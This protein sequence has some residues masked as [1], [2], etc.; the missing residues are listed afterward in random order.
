MVM[1]EMQRQGHKQRRL[2]C[3]YDSQH[4]SAKTTPEHTAASDRHPK[5]SFDGKTM[6]IPLIQAGEHGDV[7]CQYISVASGLQPLA[8]SKEAHDSDEVPSTMYIDGYAY[9]GE[10]A[11]NQAESCEYLITDKLR[12]SYITTAALRRSGCHDKDDGRKIG[13]AHV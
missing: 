9:V 7:P 2:A 1:Q 8:D 11:M 10:E 4:M 6:E 3:K 12:Q 5:A 13:R